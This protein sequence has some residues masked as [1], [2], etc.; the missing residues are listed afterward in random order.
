VFALI[1]VFGISHSGIS[2][3]TL[4]YCV[5]L[6]FFL[7]PFQQKA[8]AVLTIVFCLLFLFSLFVFFVREVGSLKVLRLSGVRLGSEPRF[9]TSGVF[10]FALSGVGWDTRWVLWVDILILARVGHGKVGRNGNGGRVCTYFFS[11]VLSRSCF[12]HTI[13]ISLFFSVLYFCHF[14]LFVCCIHISLSVCLDAA[15]KARA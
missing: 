13:I 7:S 5:F 1:V 14:F 11:S 4:L 8:H 10:L 2:Y 15:A 3:H 6:P 9:T 12:A